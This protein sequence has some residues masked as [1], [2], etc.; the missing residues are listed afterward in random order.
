[1]VKSLPGETAVAVRCMNR[2]RFCWKYCQYQSARMTSS[3]G[4]ISAGALAISAS[5]RMIFSSGLLPWMLPS[6]AILRPMA[7]MA[8]G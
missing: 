7:L 3:M 1:M 4:C 6:R 5:R 2:Q 8:T